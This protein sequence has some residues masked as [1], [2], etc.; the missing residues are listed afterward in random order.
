MAE[1]RQR[2][3]RQFEMLFPK[4]DAYDG[5]VEYHAEKHV[6]E[7]YPDAAHEKP[8]H[9]HHAAQTIVRHFPTHPCAKR[10]QGQ[11]GQLDALNAKRNADDGDHQR[12][13]RHN[14]FQGYLYAP[15]HQPNDIT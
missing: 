2:D 1:G 4:G 14:V 8:N 15:E 11:Q 7:P 5:D 12:H 6:G 3:M 13:T 10:P 9:I